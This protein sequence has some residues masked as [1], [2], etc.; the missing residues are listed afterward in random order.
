MKALTDQLSASLR[1]DASDQNMKRWISVIRDKKIPIA[2]LVPLIHAE[3]PVGMRFS[4]LLGGLCEKYPAM[5]APAIPYLFNH[6]Q[7]IDIEGF[8]RSLA[9]LFYH[10]GIPSE[11]EGEA[12]DALFR[13]LSDPASN[14]S[15]KRIALLAL[16]KLTTGYPDLIPE[17]KLVIDDLSGKYSPA[18]DK[19]LNKVMRE[20]Q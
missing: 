18:F 10:C 20:L 7:D 9:K 4:W 1:S 16:Q 2:D 12:T 14:V 19:L 15:T 17:L 13:W 6:R 5:V 8:N 11:L 3:H